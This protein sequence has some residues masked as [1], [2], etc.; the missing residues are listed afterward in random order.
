MHLDRRCVLS[1]QAQPPDIQTNSPYRI[2][3]L[4][5]SL[6]LD[7]V[8]PSERRRENSERP[9]PLDCPPMTLKF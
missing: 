1:E 5:K 8:E 9:S 2:P 7:W 6:L 3:T 4:N